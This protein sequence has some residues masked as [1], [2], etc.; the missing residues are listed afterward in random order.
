MAMCT[1]K[2]RFQVP[3]SINALA[4][5]IQQAQLTC[6]QKL[7]AP[8]V[9]EG[10]S[11]QL[12]IT[13]KILTLLEA[14]LQQ[15]PHDNHQLFLQAHHRTREKQLLESLRIHNTDRRYLALE[16]WVNA[17]IQILDPEGSS[18]EQ[19]ATLSPE[20]A[21]QQTRLLQEQKTWQDLIQKVRQ[22]LQKKPGDPQ[23]MQLLAEH[24]SRLLRLQEQLRQ[25][26]T[27]V[28]E[29]ALVLSQFEN[30]QPEANPSER[31]QLQRE[32]EVLNALCEK[33]RQRLQDKPELLH[34][35][36]LIA[37][38]EERLRTLRETLARL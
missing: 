3:L 14:R 37:Q 25:D 22:R 31:L 38:H 16:Q 24:Q 23:L 30:A 32:I 13:R 26:Q 5:E 28:R 19:K 29:E 8:D 9:R 15:A 17:K 33:T 27:G 20:E 7:S 12:K 10:L 4:P 6:L 35:K 1:P 36:G 34:L 2:P 21:A 18:E 11:Y